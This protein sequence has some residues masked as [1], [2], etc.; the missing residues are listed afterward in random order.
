MSKAALIWLW[1][2]RCASADIPKRKIS[3][4]PSGL[5]M[6]FPSPPPA[7]RVPSASTPRDAASSRKRPGPNKELCPMV[8]DDGRQLSGEGRRR[9]DTPR[10]RAGACGRGWPATSAQRRDETK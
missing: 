5:A 7:R 2:E 10:R 3:S 1:R 8:G 4:S 9:N 6:G